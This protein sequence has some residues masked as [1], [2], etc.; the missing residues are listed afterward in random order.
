MILFGQIV[1]AL[2]GATIGLFLFLQPSRTIEL[3]TKFYAC[4]N[5]RMEPI[6]MA[7]E[8]RNTKLMGLLLTGFAVFTV[9]YS[10]IIIVK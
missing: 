9:I 2:I 6:S 8:I 7:R 1:M 10:I 4:I 5:W 3:Q